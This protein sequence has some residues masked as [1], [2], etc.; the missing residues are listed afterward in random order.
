MLLSPGPLHPK[1]GSPPGGTGPVAAL[2]FTFSPQA[3]REMEYLYPKNSH[4]K[5]GP[6]HGMG[7]LHPFLQSG[8]CPMLVV[9]IWVVFDGQDWSRPAPM[10]AV[11]D[12]MGRHSSHISPVVTRIRHSGFSGSSD[13]QRVLLSSFW[14]LHCLRQRCCVVEMLC[15]EHAFCFSGWCV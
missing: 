1:S 9:L 14:S 5:T 3:I 13:C 4:Q 7:C 8:G 11:M 12:S 15:D 6:S 10:I 2:G